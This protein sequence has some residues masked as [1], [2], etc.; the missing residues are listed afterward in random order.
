MALLMFLTWLHST[1]Y[2]VQFNLLM[3]L[4]ML[5]DA[6]KKS[7]TAKHDVSRRDIQNDFDSSM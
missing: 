6:G 4:K 1:I 5:T 7:N 2:L 3:V